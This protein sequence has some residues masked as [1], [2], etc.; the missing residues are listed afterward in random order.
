MVTRGFVGKVGQANSD[1]A[2]RLPPGQHVVTDFPVLSAGPTPRI[3]TEDWTFTLKV[4]PRIVTKWNWAEFNALPQTKM[5][6]DTLE[7]R[8]GA[9]RS[10]TSSGEDECA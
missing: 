9:P 4:A 7:K 10:R 1:Q 2:T 5:T 3:R 8:S 6:R